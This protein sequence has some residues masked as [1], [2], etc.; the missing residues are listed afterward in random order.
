MNL[1]PNRRKLLT[2]CACIVLGM[3]VYPPLQFRGIGPGYG[4]IFS[5]DDGLAVNASQ[6]LFQWIGVA[7][8]GVI[9]YVV[10]GDKGSGPR[11]ESSSVGTSFLKGVRHQRCD[12]DSST[13]PSLR[14]S[15]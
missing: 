8:I 15:H 7:I 14:C 10:L 9:A 5:P 6:L 3:L 13:G 11:G 4:W 12:S 1:T 2:I